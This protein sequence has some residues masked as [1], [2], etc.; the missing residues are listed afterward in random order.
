MGLLKDIF[1]FTMMAFGATI[2]LDSIKYPNLLMLINRVVF[3]AFLIY[4][5]I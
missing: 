2:I 5:I 1:H 3:T 4:K